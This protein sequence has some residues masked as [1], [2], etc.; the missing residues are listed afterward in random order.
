MTYS[1]AQLLASAGE[2]LYGPG[3]WQ[4]PLARALRVNRRT[5]QRWML[6]QFNPSPV[7]WS[8]ID[9]L[10]LERRTNIDRVRKHL[11]TDQS[12]VIGHR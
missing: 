12:E 1:R 10:L 11:P 9:A 8:E 6:G 3:Q 2:A 4:S 7:V 5:V